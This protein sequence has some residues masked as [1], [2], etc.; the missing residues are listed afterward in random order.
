MD[1]NSESVNFKIKYRPG[2]SNPYTLSDTDAS[3]QMPVTSAISVPK[4]E[5]ANMPELQSKEPDLAHIIN[6]LQSGILPGN[7][8]DER[9]TN[10]ISTCCKMVFYIICL[11]LVQHIAGRKR[12]V[13]W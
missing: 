4:F 7:S 3:S 5:P 12:A 1:R 13:S 10:L 9:T 6:Y 11:A 8:S 2:C